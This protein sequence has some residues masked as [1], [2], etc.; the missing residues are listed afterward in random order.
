MKLVPLSFAVLALA[1]LTIVS[2]CKDTETPIKTV[3]WKKHVIEKPNTLPEG[4]PSSVNT[5]VAA[6]FDNDGQMDVI[7]SFDGKVFLYKG[8]QWERTVILDE[9]PAN[10][11][12][13]H[14]DR[15]CIHS[16]LMDVNG[17]GK[18]D[19][20]GANRMLF[21]LECP[22]NPFTDPWPLRMINLEVNGAHCVTTGDVDSDGKLDLIANSWRDS[23][24]STIPNSITWLKVPED[25]YEDKLWTPHVFADKDAPGGNH[26][27]GFGDVNKDGRPDIACGAKGGMPGGNWFAWWEQPENP[28]GPWKKHVLSDNEPGATNILPVDLDG[29]GHVDYVASR[30]HGKG[31]LWFKGPEFKKIEIDPNISSPHSL[32]I[33]DINGD[34]FTDVVTCSAS[35]NGETVIYYNDGKGNFTRHV[36]D[37]KQASYDIRPVDMDGDGDLDILIA[38]HRSRNVVWYENLN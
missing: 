6:D 13:V 24:E 8:P 37:T 14:A 11:K 34:G 7:S 9:M 29:D 32:E 12:G 27:M 18:M 30:G 20:V 38:G 28:E 5:V 23:S 26:Y 33:G 3:S 2:S 35:L 25:P 15:G 16:T 36:I 10:W 21:W 1:T 17:D 31:V 22:P 4:Q 19:Y